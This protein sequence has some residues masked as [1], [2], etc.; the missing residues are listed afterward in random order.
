MRKWWKIIQNIQIEKKNN[1]KNIIEHGRIDV[2]TF[3][4]QTPEHFILNLIQH[5]INNAKYRLHV[6]NLFEDFQGNEMCVI[7][8]LSNDGNV[9]KKEN[10]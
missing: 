2:P 5:C 7:S 4:V 3:N 10:L 1:P 6:N 8:L 9:I